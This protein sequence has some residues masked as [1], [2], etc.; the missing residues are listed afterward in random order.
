MSQVNFIDSVGLGIIATAYSLVKQ[1]NRSLILCKVNDPVRLI[2]E[3]TGLDKALD[4]S[5]TIPHSSASGLSHFNEQWSAISV[6][7]SAKW[8]C[9]TLT[10]SGVLYS[11]EISLLETLFVSTFAQILCKL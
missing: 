2:F 1:Q 10:L 9:S 11:E 3:L 5:S 8:D 7:L 4:F 6:S